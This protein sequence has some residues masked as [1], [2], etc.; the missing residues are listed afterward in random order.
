MPTDCDGVNAQAVAFVGI[1]PPLEKTI[2]GVVVQYRYLLVE[3]NSK[4]NIKLSAWKM[5]IISAE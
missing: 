4:Q 1:T 2:S 3:K 5:G